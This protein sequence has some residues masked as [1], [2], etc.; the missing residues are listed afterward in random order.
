MLLWMPCSASSCLYAWLAYLAAAIRVM[1][2][3]LRRS[4]VLQCH[5]KGVQNDVVFE[6]FTQ[7]PA[8]HAARE[9]IE[10]LPPGTTNP[11][12]STHG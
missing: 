5:L 7:R 3:T 6:P 11:P 8:D 2:Q 1:Q 12:G 4:A 9:Q 10:C